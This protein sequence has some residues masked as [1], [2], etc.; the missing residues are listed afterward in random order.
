M[1]ERTM[2]KR[3]SIKL[4]KTEKR[5]PAP[6]EEVITPVEEKGS[7]QRA[8]KKAPKEEEEQIQIAPTKA[9]VSSSMKVFAVSWRLH[10]A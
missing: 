7:Y 5:A 10:T 1:T 2:K 8:P 4:E 3:E 9:E 6:V